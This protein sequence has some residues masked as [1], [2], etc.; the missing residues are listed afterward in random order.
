MAKINLYFGNPCNDWVQETV[1]KITINNDI[2]MGQAAFML[3]QKLVATISK[4][5]PQAS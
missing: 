2:S 1:T 4:N 5:P 3:F